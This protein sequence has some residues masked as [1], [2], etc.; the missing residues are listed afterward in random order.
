[1]EY[2]LSLVSVIAGIFV[3]H[4]LTVR[5]SKMQVKNDSIRERRKELRDLYRDIIRVGY[6]LTANYVSPEEIDDAEKMR[7]IQMNPLA[8]GPDSR[9]VFEELRRKHPTLSIRA[10]EI[11][12]I[13]KELRRITADVNLI[14]DDAPTRK[15]IENFT[16]VAFFEDPPE[17]A[18]YM[19]IVGSAV[20]D[21][22]NVMTKSIS[23][24]A[25]NK[26]FKEKK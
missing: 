20:D 5:L 17:K 7:A 6:E 23:D 25:L 10:I 16:R 11:D 9:L 1:M 15:A 8:Y 14:V 4:L 18:E 21:M 13:G 19:K 2:L 26:W 3:G 12:R 22:L 24:D